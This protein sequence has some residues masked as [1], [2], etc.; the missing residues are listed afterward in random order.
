MITLSDFGSISA[1]DPLF[2]SSNEVLPSLR[3]HSPSSASV[4]RS[5]KSCL[6]QLNSVEEVIGVNTAVILPEQGTRY[7]IEPHKGSVTCSSTGQKVVLRPIPRTE[8]LALTV[9]PTEFAG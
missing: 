9:T 1:V 5:R 7:A 2:V 6:R 4:E 8:T 3:V